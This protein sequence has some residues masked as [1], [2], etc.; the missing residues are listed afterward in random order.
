MAR[1]LWI[2]AVF[3]LVPCS[4]AGLAHAAYKKG[5]KPLILILLDTSASMEYLP[6]WN[7]VIPDCAT[8]FNPTFGA[9][10]KSKLIMAQELLTGTFENYWCQYTYPP[11]LQKIPSLNG[12]TSAPGILNGLFPH[13]M[14][15]AGMAADACTNPTQ[16][17]DGLM[18]ILRDRARFSLMTTD[19]WPQWQYTNDG[20]WSYPQKAKILPTTSDLAKQIKPWLGDNRINLG[21]KNARW[22][23]PDFPNEWDGTRWVINDEN[24]GRSQT[25]HGQLVPPPATDVLTDLRHQNRVAQAEVIRAT[26]AWGSPLAAMFN[27]VYYFFKDDPDV[28]AYDPSTGQGDPLYECRTK[29]IIWISDGQ[30]NQEEWGYGD[31]LGN[32]A[33]AFYLDGLSGG[34]PIF[35]VNFMADPFGLDTPNGYL[36]SADESLLNASSGFEWLRDLVLQSNRTFLGPTV[37]ALK[38][39]VLAAIA[40]TQH[41]PETETEIITTDATWS[42]LDRQYQFGASWQVDNVDNSNLEGFLEQ[43]IYRC[44]NTCAGVTAG[45]LSCPQETL[46]L[47]ERLNDMPSSHRSLYASFHGERE[48][49]DVSLLNQSHSGVLP[50]D[51]AVPTTGRLPQPLSNASDTYDATDHAQRKQYVQDLIKHIRAD[52]DSLRAKKRLGAITRSTPV[53]QQAASQGQYPLASWKRYV[54][55]DTAASEGQD[56]TYG[57]KCRPTMLYA[58]THDGLLHA[59]RVDHFEGGDGRCSDTLPAQ[60]DQDVG[61]ESWAIIPHH[62]LKRA[63]NLVGRYDYL[64]E[65]KSTWPMFF[66]DARRRLW[67]SLRSKLKA[68]VLCSPWDTAEEDVGISPWM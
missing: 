34:A 49:L 16:K 9:H 24:A 42:T 14:P 65:V 51:F 37:N 52:D 26:T 58:G 12:F 54:Q 31:V 36:T 44:S 18:D 38:K 30:A 8:D 19:S 3:M 45:G 13:A 21:V 60:S 17:A 61:K 50:S 6:D 47:H 32:M 15:C 2:I 10:T 22:G 55:G 20:M 7:Y 27:D 62:L 63:H 40:Q 64:M 43:T 41:D 48:A 4:W 53:I 5:A 46:N 68:G 67:E 56:T 57:P 11:E 39:G 1:V 28:K 66:W 35:F 59:F 33:K 29:I 23:D 25:N